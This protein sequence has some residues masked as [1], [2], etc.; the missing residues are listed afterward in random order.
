MNYG[1]LTFAL[2]LAALTVACGKKPNRPLRSRPTRQNP[3]PL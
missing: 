1:R 3:P 2:G